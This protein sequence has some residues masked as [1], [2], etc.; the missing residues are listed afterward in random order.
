MLLKL[1][2]STLV[3]PSCPPTSPGP[4]RGRHALERPYPVDMTPLPEKVQ[5]KS[6]IVL[7]IVS[8][9]LAACGKE[10]K[11]PSERA[12]AASA[13]ETARPASAVVPEAAP[14]EDRAASARVSSHSSRASRRER[15]RA[16]SAAAS[17]PSD[18]THTV[19][20]GETLASI[21]KSRGLKAADVA[22][23]NNV[24]DPRRLRIGQE[25]RLAAP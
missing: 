5:M 9:A 17:G 18:A 20:R 19:A 15:A 12:A 6:L 14:V 8:L 13:T 11:P 3:R 10:D 16:A 4:A 2:E 22:R 25:L 1:F 7:T 23:W 24:R 21:A